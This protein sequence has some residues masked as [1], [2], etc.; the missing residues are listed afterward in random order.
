M[1]QKISTATKFIYG[2]G[3]VACNL[4]WTT[5]GSFLTLYYT[6]TVLI[7]A[8]F[9]G[10]MMLISRILDGVSDL[11]MGV[12]IDRTK[13]KMGHARPWVLWGGLALAVSLVLVFN[14]PSSLSTTGKETYV[15][16]TYIFTCVFAFTAANLAYVVLSNL[17][18]S[19]SNERNSLNSCRFFLTF[20]AVIILN[21]Y[22]AIWQE[23]LGGGQSGWTKLTIIFGALSAIL[24]V[25]IVVFCKE[26]PTIENANSEEQ[27][28]SPVT[29]AKAI[30]LGNRYGITMVLMYISFYIALVGS[31]GAAIYFARDVMGDIGYMVQ[32]TMF[33]LVPG[34]VIML[35]IPKFTEIVGVWKGMLIGCGLFAVGFLLTYIAGTNITMIY[36]AAVIR[37]LGQAVISPLMVTLVSQL[38][39]YNC[40]KNDMP[41][42]GVTNCVVSVGNKVGTGLAGAIIGWSLAY[43]GYDGAIAV[44]SASTI[45]CEKMLY[46]IV[47]FI[48][49]VL[50]LI[51]T[52]GL[53]MDKALKE[54][55]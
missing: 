53:N 3:D 14:V 49:A 16:I 42:V 32:L 22:T 51:F 45:F 54:L 6:D 4:V 21:S 34:V 10:T 50:C 39:D 19:D 48:A 18:T 31:N 33:S 15:F 44:Q 26:D 28:V 7:S 47:P 41:L 1:K 24:F 55:E 46:C 2:T 23:K 13:S 29:A 30:F 5:M 25:L 9:V 52:T 11:L 40:K 43:A 35:L 37:G 12:V 8:A 38:A 20:I 36:V 17:M 27:K